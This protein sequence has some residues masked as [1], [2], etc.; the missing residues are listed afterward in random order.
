MPLNVPAWKI[1]C[2]LPI[3][4]FFIYSNSVIVIALTACA[5]LYLLDG[6]WS[7]LSSEC[8]AYSVH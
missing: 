1:I 6:Y 7:N 5:V 8:K 3:E 2:T 4:Q